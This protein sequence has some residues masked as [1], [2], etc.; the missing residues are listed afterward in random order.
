[1]KNLNKIFLFLL[2]AIFSQNNIIFGQNNNPNISENI[3]QNN[4]TQNGHINI[5]EKFNISKNCSK[6]YNNILN[7]NN[8]KLAAASLITPFA[9][10]AVVAGIKKFIFRQNLSSN[11]I[12]HATVPALNWGYFTGL[13]PALLYATC[14]YLAGKKT[15]EAIHFG[16]TLSTLNSTMIAVLKT[17]I[18]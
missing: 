18:L 3:P 16:L 4:I 11:L 6:I 1:M 8:K 13:T 9:A 14:N 15:E 5:N 7:M 17:V 12:Y 2:A 10:S